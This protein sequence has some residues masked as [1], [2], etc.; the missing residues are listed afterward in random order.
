MKKN[1]LQYASKQNNNKKKREMMNWGSLLLFPS[2]WKRAVFFFFFFSPFYFASWLIRI[3]DE[4]D[5]QHVGFLWPK[6]NEKYPSFQIWWQGF[7]K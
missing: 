4:M 2:Q 5:I 1:G 3:R 6:L 7:T